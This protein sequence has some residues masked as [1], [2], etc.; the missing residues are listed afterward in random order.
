METFVIAF[1]LIF[2]VA[3]IIIGAIGAQKR[4]SS[5][6]EIKDT[7]LE[8]GYKPQNLIE[9]QSSMV[10]VDPDINQLCL[11]NIGAK[12][13][14]EY[15]LETIRD[16]EIINNGKT[17]FKKSNTIGRAVIGGLLF[18]G[19]GALVG[20]AGAK[21]TGKTQ[22]TSAILKL[23]TTNIDA[24]SIQIKIFDATLKDVKLINAYIQRAQLFID[25][26]AITI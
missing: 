17:V 2:G 1:L 12:N 18:G 15:P 14:L 10:G 7:L 5:I 16:F 6:Q 3:A 9:L 26:L 13:I 22:I 19:V 20:V 24:P 11:V 25:K 21:S 4:E 23:Y 8:K